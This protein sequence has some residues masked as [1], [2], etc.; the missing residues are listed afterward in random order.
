MAR[1]Q[2]GS[3]LAAEPADV[4]ADSL[5]ERLQCLESSAAPS[6]VNTGTIGRVVVDCGEDRCRSVFALDGCRPVGAP[7]IWLGRLVVICPLC[8]C[9]AACG[10]LVGAI[11]WTS[12]ISRSTRGFAVRISAKQGRAKIFRCLSR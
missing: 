3:D 10:R 12:R 8:S 11:N 5:A 9:S 4:F 1:N 7:H 2:T 6:D